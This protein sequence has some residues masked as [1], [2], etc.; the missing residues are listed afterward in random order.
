M[1]VRPAPSIPVVALP[2]QRKRPNPFVRIVRVRAT[3]FA[4][5]ILALVFLAAILAPIV[6]P[7]DPL[8]TDL[9]GR[10]APPSSRHWFGQDE[11]GSDISIRFV[12]GGRVSLSVGIVSVS[13]GVVLVS[14]IGTVAGFWRRADGP[15]LRFVDV[16]LAF[17]FV[18]RALAIVAI[19]GAGYVN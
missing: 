17:P 15:I 4:L 19:L 18:L 13:L 3:W 12:L 1:G 6:A 10:L 11:V 2:L 8:K 14:M 9:L 16:L 7:Y 5:G